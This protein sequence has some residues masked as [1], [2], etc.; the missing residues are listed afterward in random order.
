MDNSRLIPVFIDKS[1]GDKDKQSVR[2]YYFIVTV[3][4][5]SFRYASSDLERSPGFLAN[6]FKPLSVTATWLDSVHRFILSRSLDGSRFINAEKIELVFDY[7]DRHNLNV[8]TMYHTFT[9][10]PGG[11]CLTFERGQVYRLNT[12]LIIFNNLDN[13]EEP[14][15]N[16]NNMLYSSEETEAFNTWNEN[17][18]SP[19]IMRYKMSPEESLRGRV[20][21]TEK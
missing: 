9:N 14:I 21:Q 15:I 4:E 10:F 8:D 5:S 3:E 16:N 17:V 7:L 19:I 2:F 11:S 6:I 18:L 20:R 1:A 12:D 13:G